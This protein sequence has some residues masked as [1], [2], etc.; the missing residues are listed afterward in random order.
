MVASPVL[1]RSPG[2]AR[3]GQFKTLGPDH[4]SEGGVGKKV[5]VASGMAGDD[6]QPARP[7]MRTRRI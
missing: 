2:L 7:V 3:V 1:V 6:A 4:K 5:Q